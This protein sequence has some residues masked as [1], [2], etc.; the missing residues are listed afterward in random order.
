MLK[1]LLEEMPAARR[2]P[3]RYQEAEPAKARNA[4]APA[5]AGMSR[6]R[7][8]S[9]RATRLNGP[10]RRRIRAMSCSTS[11]GSGLTTRRATASALFPTND[12]RSPKRCSRAMRVP[13]GFSGGRQDLPRGAD[14]G[15]RARAGARHAVRADRPLIGGANGARRPSAR[16]Q[17][18]DPDGDAATFDVLAALERSRPSIPIPKPSSSASSRCSRGCTRSRP[19]RAATP[20]EVAPDRRCGALRR[21]AAARAWASPRRSSPTGSAGRARQGL[22]SRRRTASPCRPIRDADHHGRARHRHRAVPLLPA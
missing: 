11:A 5:T 22:S 21:L 12:P 19:R 7:R 9:A 18:S 20:G 17:A 2:K 13:A 1:R 4:G 10:G 14:R 8:S 3:R 16:G 6:S 15:L